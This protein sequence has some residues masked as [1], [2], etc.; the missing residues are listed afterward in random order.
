MAERSDK[1]QLL[2]VR[3][4]RNAAKKV[5]RDIPKDMARDLRAISDKVVEQAQSKARGLPGKAG[6]AFAGGLKS[7]TDQT[8]AKVTLDGSRFPTLLGDEFGAKQYPQFQPWR[9]NAYTDPLGQN[10]GY[11]LHPVLRESRADIDRQATE[12]VDRWLHRLATE[13]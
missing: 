11:A 6:E 10:V 4:F 13:S 12:L 9:G 2:G 5:N 1:V 3:E 8:A 7:R